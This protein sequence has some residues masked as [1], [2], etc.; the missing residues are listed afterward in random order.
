VEIAGSTALVTG[1][2]SGIGRATAETLAAEGATVAVA[3]LDEA[4]GAAT[5]E[6]ISARGGRAFFV[7]ADVSTPMGVDGLFSAV[8]SRAGAPQ[9]VHNNAGIMT[10]DPPGWPE[11]S[12]GQLDRVVSIN[13]SGVILGTRMALEVMRERGGVVVNTASI[14]GLGPLPRD[15]VYAGTKA[16]VVH[17]TRSCAELATSHGVRVNAVLP[18]V[19]DTPILADPSPWL[20]ELLSQVEKIPPQAV[21]DCVLGLVRDDGAAGVCRVVDPAGQRDA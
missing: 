1:A 19:T 21:A 9:I 14:A 11:A 6:R 16:L 8:V 13:A 20:R 7:A 12:L 10:A 2:A 15:P 4:G 17:F 3:D 18:A 5:V